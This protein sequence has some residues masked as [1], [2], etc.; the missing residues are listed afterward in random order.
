LREIEREH[1][2]TQWEAYL[3]KHI[4]TGE[5]EREKRVRKTKRKGRHKKN[6]K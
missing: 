6:D 1:E 3:V 2:K 5:A 4:F